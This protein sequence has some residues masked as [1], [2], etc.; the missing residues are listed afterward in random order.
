[1]RDKQHDAALLQHLLLDRLVD[2]PEEAWN[3]GTRQNDWFRR[4]SNLERSERELMSSPSQNPRIQVEAPDQPNDFQTNARIMEAHHTFPRL[5]V[6]VLYGLVL[7]ARFECFH[8]LCIG[9]PETHGHASNLWLV[10]EVKRI[11]CLGCKHGQLE[12]AHC[13]VIIS[14]P[15]RSTQDWFDPVCA[16]PCGAKHAAADHRQPQPGPSGLLTTACNGLV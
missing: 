8:L 1:M 5:V 6:L 2:L 11:T 9:S 14:L 15:G 13:K 3:P 4:A 7:N 12:M 16:S 10:L